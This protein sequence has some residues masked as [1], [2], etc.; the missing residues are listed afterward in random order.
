MFALLLVLLV[1]AGCSP[2]V[3]AGPE[4]VVE[5]YL[6]AIVDGDEDRIATL[7][8]ANWE[9][10]AR[11]DVAAFYGV[12]ARLEDVT[13]QPVENSPA[14]QGDEVVVDCSGAIVATYNEEDSTFE[15]AGRQF[16]VINQS[17]EWLVCGY[18]E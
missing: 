11:A 14:G 2:A 8:C 3:D 4:K 13:C 9:A 18:A 5:S 16:Q 17:G 10:S 1:F 12:Q 6:Q 7:S 15:L